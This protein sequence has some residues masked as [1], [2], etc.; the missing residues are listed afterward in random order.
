MLVLNNTPAGPVIRIHPILSGFFL[1]VSIVLSVLIFS[2]IPALNYKEFVNQ[3]IIKSVILTELS[4]KPRINNISQPLAPHPPPPSSEPKLPPKGLSQSTENRFAMD[5]SNSGGLSGSSDGVSIGGSGQIQGE[6]FEEGQT[7]TEAKLIRSVSPEYPEAAMRAGVSGKVEAILTIGTD[8]KVAEIQI[9]NKLGDY[10]FDQ[11][12][13]EAV[14]NWIYEP[15]TVGGAP[16][17][18]RIKQPFMF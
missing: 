18:I 6:T 15:A 3:T 5:L 16:V 2:F 13:R 4:K 7:D 10:G 17:R 14:K 11:A 9:L 12:I 8:G 1:V